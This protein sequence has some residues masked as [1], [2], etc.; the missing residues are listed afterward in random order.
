MSATA[1]NAS[2]CITAVFTSAGDKPGWEAEISCVAA[3]QPILAELTASDPTRNAA[4]RDYIDVCVGD[5][6]TLTGG[7]RYPENNSLYPQSDATS[8]LGV[9]VWG[10]QLADRSY[11]HPYLL[12]AGGIHR[13]A[14]RHRHEGL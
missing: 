12:R 2:G 5:P 7:A 1:A 10:R 6:V 3:C 8:T 4:N 13:R 14:R 11:G 9:D